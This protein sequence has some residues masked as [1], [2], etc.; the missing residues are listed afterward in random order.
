MLEHCPS[1]PMPVT[2]PRTKG[3]PLS[4]SA[5]L[6]QAVPAVQDSDRLERLRGVA[7]RVALQGLALSLPTILGSCDFT[8]HLCT[9]IGTQS[10]KLLVIPRFK[11]NGF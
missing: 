10:Y 7:S 4:R 2:T 11:T 9:G 1:M 3:L 8:A 5:D 6:A